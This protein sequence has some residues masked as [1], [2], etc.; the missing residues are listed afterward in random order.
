M[1]AP[2]MVIYSTVN[3]AG[4]YG[5]GERWPLTVIFLFLCSLSLAII[6]IYL[7]SGKQIAGS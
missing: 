7:R 2:G 4:Y 6:S 5:E 3:A 1:M